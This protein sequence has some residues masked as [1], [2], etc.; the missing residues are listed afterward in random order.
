MYEK[1]YCAPNMNN[2]ISCYG[3]EELK[4]MAISIN[5]THRNRIKLSSNHSDLQ[6]QISEYV[7]QNSDCMN[8]ACWKELPK[9]RSCVKHSKHFKPEYPVKWLGKKHQLSTSNINNVLEQ[10]QDK[11]NTFKY[12]G[13]LP[14]DFDLKEQNSCMVSDICN[15]SLSKLMSDGIKD[16][17]IV[18]NTDPHTR[19]GEHWMSMYVDIDGSN[20]HHS[21]KLPGI[22]FFDSYGY[23]PCSKVTKLIERIKDQGKK[24]NIDFQ[25]FHNDK[26]YQRGNY[27]CGVYS[28]HFIVEMLKNKSFNDYLNK[29]I[30][31]DELIDLVK[32]QYYINPSKVKR[33]KK[34]KRRKKSELKELRGG[35]ILDQAIPLPCDK[36]KWETEFKGNNYDELMETVEGPR[37]DHG[38]L[39]RFAKENKM[40]CYEFESIYTEWKRLKITK[41]MEE[42]EDKF[43]DFFI[44]VETQTEKSK[45][46]FRETQQQSPRREYGRGNKKGGQEKVNAQLK[47]FAETNG[48]ECDEMKDIY[49]KWGEAEANMI[50]QVFRNP[51]ISDEEIEAAKESDYPIESYQRLLDKYPRLTKK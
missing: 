28:I 46:H 7:R 12:Y 13:A 34:L 30:L 3:I 17:G 10:Y 4:K 14:I 24:S 43:Y 5:K 18:F 33:T 40:E 15:M 48:M 6:K 20:F 11:Y 2:G 45:E 35:S 38:E 19:G 47:R 32:Y 27:H 23:K 9:I 8:E 29:K 51:E 1:Y 39:L 41:C 42:F 50:D 26:R 21:K 37:P 25:L 44:G 49:K 16:V 22:Y 36:D 31:N